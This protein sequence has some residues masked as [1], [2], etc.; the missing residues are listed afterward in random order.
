MAQHSSTADSHDSHSASHGSVKSYI[1]GF[2]LC[3]VLT[4]MSFGVVMGDVLTGFA[5]ASALIALCV[6]QLVVQLVF[7]LHMGTSPEQRENL[8]SFLFTLLIIAIIVGGSAWVLHN[9]NANM[10]VM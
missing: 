2:A 8:S 7:F 5:A 3:I 10:M 1:I 4:L 9:M 6:L